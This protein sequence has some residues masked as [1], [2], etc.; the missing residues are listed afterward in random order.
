MPSLSII[1]ASAVADERLTD[2]QVRVL[3][4]IG[5]FTN[6]LG[7][8]VWASVRTLASS[9]NLNP[10]T[11]QRALPVLLEHGYLHVQDRPGRTNLYGIV[12]DQPTTPVSPPGDSSVTPPPTPVSPKRLKERSPLTTRDAQFEA[13]ME[14]IWRT[15]PKRPEPYP[16]P[17]IRKAVAAHVDMGNPIAALVLAVQR[18]AQVVAKEQTEPR[19]VRSPVRFFY[20]GDWQNYT[21][22]TVH[23]RT[24]DEWARSGQ[25]VLE[26]DRLAAGGGQ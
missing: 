11:V 24:R 3:C 20:E 16:Y 13:G 10:R 4:A 7:G 2:A 12:L 19:Y 23:G 14:T 6:K 22:V 26:F 5:T 15:Y 8:N 1:P 17:A 9:C 18:Y 21:E 25:D